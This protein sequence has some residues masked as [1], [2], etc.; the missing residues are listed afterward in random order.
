VVIVQSFITSD[1]VFSVSLSVPGIVCPKE[2]L[3]RA[4]RAKSIQRYFFPQLY[5]EN[6]NCV[7]F[8][9]VSPCK[10]QGLAI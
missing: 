8:I 1:V 10:P 3:A 6:K 7:V 9:E 2:E 4:A 5:A